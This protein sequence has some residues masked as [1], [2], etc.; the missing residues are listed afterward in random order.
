TYWQTIDDASGY[1]TISYSGFQSCTIDL[2]EGRFSIVGD[3]ITFSDGTSSLTTVSIGP[4]TVIEAAI[5]GTGS[6]RL[7]GNG[8]N[9]VLKGGGGGD[10]L[11]GGAGGDQLF[12][13]LDDDVLTGSSGID[14]FVFNTGLT[15]ATPNVD[16]ITDFSV[17]DDTIRLD[18]AVFTK[19]KRGVLPASKFTIGKQA[20]DSSDRIIYDKRTGDLFY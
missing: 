19:L 7:I 13:G 5:G 15:S 12:G 1:D 4:G 20:K 9:N 6:D 18:D 17:K 11:Y 16:R 2:R 14:Y 3:A 8:A 10:R